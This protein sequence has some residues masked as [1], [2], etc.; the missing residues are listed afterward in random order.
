MLFAAYYFGSKKRNLSIAVP[1][2][3][4]ALFILHPV[5]RH[6]WFFSLYWLIPVIGKLP[7][8]IPGKLFVRSLG[9]TFT[10]HAVGTAT[11]IW[12]VP[13]GAEAWVALIP[14]VFVERILFA[15]GIAISYVVLNTVLDKAVY[16]I[17][18]KVR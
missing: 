5:G 12:S 7:F 10:A 4:M 13:M 14:V 8:N 18:D 3:C 2:V 9:A 16:A 17:K 6:V 1:L 11:W 15:S